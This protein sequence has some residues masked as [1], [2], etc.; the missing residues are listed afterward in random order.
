MLCPELLII[1]YDAHENN[2][3]DDDDND[4]NNR[5]REIKLYSFLV[6]QE[7]MWHHLHILIIGH[8]NSYELRSSKFAVQVNWK[9]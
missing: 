3:G 2:D 9:V 7:S 6:K 4:N 1:F 5:D 8:F